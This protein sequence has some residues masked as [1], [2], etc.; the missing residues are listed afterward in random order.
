[1]SGELGDPDDT[2]PAKP[3]AR[4]DQP[5]NEP[6]SPERPA[7]REWVPAK[8][9]AQPRVRRIIAIVALLAVTGAGIAALYGSG[10]LTGIFAGRA[11]AT[12]ARPA[13]PRT[14]PARVAPPVP[15]AP[16]VRAPE[17]VLVTVGGAP[18]GSKVF[19]DGVLVPMNPFRV[20]RRETIVALRVEA[21]GYQPFSIAVL[22]TD[23]QTVHVAMAPLKVASPHRTGSG[24]GTLLDRG[25]ASAGGTRTM[26]EQKAVIAKNKGELKRCYDLALHRRDVPAETDLIVHFRLDVR[27]SGRVGGTELTGTGA[28]VPAFAE[29]LEREVKTWV[30]APS[31]GDAV[32]AFSFAFTTSG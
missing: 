30:F 4:K 21:D 26:S 16:Q 10:A 24:H 32:V 29:C 18:E 20:E 15:T 23:D 9:A 1:V 17:G 19:W 3:G 13:V 31:T 22:P 28:A 5:G 14:P 11:P 27:S 7:E 12:D 8:R 6:R 25:A 2:L